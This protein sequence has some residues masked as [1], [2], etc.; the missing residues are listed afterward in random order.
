MIHAETLSQRRTIRQQHVTVNSVT[1]TGMAFLKRAYDKVIH[2]QDQHSLIICEK[3]S[4]MQICKIEPDSGAIV[5]WFND[6]VFV[7]IV[8]VF[9]VV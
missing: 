3:D 6:S 2:P 4:N 1:K 8:F 5:H 9:I 7:F